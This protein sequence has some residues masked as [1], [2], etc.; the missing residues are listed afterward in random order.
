MIVTGPTVVTPLL[1]RLTL[2]PRV[3]QLLV[4]EGVLIDPV[5]AVVAIVAA[6]WIVGRHELVASGWR[7]L[8]SLGVGGFLGVVAGLA[9]ARALRRGW[10]ADLLVESRHALHVVREDGQRKVLQ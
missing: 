6:E 4:S 1:A 7:V 5:G 2:T 8:A 9:A 10:I 3:R